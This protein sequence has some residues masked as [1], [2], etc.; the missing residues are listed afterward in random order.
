MI[1]PASYQVLN[2]KKA[3]YPG[4]NHAL[5]GHPH[6]DFPGTQPI[7]KPRLMAFVVSSL[8]Y[9]LHKLRHGFKA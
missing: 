2:C 9:G 6:P 8:L 4:N 7:E 3:S 1:C 5:G